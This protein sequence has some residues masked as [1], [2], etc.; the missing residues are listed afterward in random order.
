MATTTTTVLDW[1]VQRFPTAKRQTLK[2][3]VE[4]GRVRVNGRPV[5][6]LK[7][8]IGDADRVEVDESARPP[9][10][11]AVAAAGPSDVHVVYE[12]ADLLVVHKPPGLLTSTVPREPR[13]TL[14]AKVRQYVAAIDPQA[15]VG[16]IHRLD[17]AASGLLVFSKNNEAYESLKKQF[18]EHSVDRVYTAVVEGKPPEAKGRIRSRLTELIDGRVVST[19]SED[20]GQTAITDYVLLRHEQTPAGPRSLL[21]VVLQTGRKHQIR[22]HLS[23]RGTPIVNDPVYGTTKKPAGRLMLVATS[24]ALAHPRTREQMTFEIPI[25]KELKDAVIPA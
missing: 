23:E 2:R 25:P 17:R 6:R 9:A 3:M 22:A 4:A 19:Q 16:L 10:K 13:P 18:F 7:Q 20:K 21:R 8:S 15:R 5:A 11:S 24:L 12:D 14:L 1:L